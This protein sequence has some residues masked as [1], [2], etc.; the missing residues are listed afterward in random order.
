[1]CKDI[2]PGQNP[3]TA[4]KKNM[5]KM[6]ISIYRTAKYF[7]LAGETIPDPPICRGILNI[8]IIFCVAE[9]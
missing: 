6:V 5:I 4:M 1:M 2:F 9:D 8:H 3:P 7:G